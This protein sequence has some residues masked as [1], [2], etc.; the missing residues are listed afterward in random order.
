MYRDSLDDIV[1]MVNSK[2]LEHLNYRELSDEL[3][4]IKTTLSA[5]NGNQ[6]AAADQPPLD[7]KL[8]D[9][10]PLLFEAAAVPETIRVDRLLT[11]FKK[12][13]QQI[14]LVIDEY[15]GTV[16]LV[17][18]ADVLE[19]VF[20]DLPDEEETEPDILKRPDGSVQIAG[21]VSIDE[22]NELFGVGFPTNDA[23]TM[24]GLVLNALGRVAMVGDEVEINHLRLRVE[25]VDRFRI[26]T[27]SLFFPPDKTT[28]T[29]QTD[30][31]L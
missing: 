3:E 17:T 15:G 22:I 21:N 14:A 1:G 16:G 26:A 2:D 8:L 24:A 18:L 30:L 5:G 19:Q 29:V 28:E 10:S 13:R 25:K 20:G 27:L 9:L 4:H 7:E 31:D 12:R 23:V 6:Q 11:E